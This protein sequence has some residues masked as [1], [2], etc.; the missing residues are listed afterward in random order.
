MKL[1]D[2]LIL[3]PC[4]GIEDFCTHLEDHEANSLLAAWCGSWHPQLLAA[5]GGLPRWCRVDEIPESP[6]ATVLVVPSGSKELIDESVCARMADGGGLL[7][8]EPQSPEEVFPSIVQDAGDPGM[9]EMRG[10]DFELIQ[11]QGFCISII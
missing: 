9:A 4:C 5:T 6:E 1:K 2:L 11:D 3:V 8:E 7:V 10:L